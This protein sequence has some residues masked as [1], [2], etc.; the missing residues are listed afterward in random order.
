MKE[1][2]WIQAQIH[3]LDFLGGATRLLVSD[4]L[5]TGILQNR[6]HEDPIANR[7]YQELGNHYNMV[8]LPVRV[9]APKDKAAVEG[10]VGQATTHIIAKLRKRKFF[11]LYEMNMSIREEL[12]HSEVVKIVVAN[13][14]DNFVLD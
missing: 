11:D 1:E 8:L 2:S 12:D 6:K 7:S 9:L 13:H 3:L 10:S 5:K 4:N 14:A